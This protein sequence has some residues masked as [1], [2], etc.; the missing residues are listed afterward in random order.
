M[1]ASYTP[2]QLD[3]LRCGY[4]KMSFR[5]LTEAFNERFGTTRSSEQI[6]SCLFNH[7]ITSGRTGRFKKGHDVW[8]RGL[9]GSV[10]PNRTSFKPGHKPKNKR[11]LWAERVT[12][13]GYI[14]ISIPER[15]PYTGAPTRFKLK[16]KWLW[17]MEHGPVPKGHCLIFKDGDPLNC[18]IDNLLLVHRSVLLSLNL[19]KYR[20]AS[21]ELKPS[22]LAL[23]E[24]EAKAGVRSRPGRRRGKEVSNG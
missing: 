9:K 16:N 3:F 7:C 6:K 8:N 12:R 24:L 20:E 11:R 1:M 23:A 14:E 10:S 22:I 5:D 13:D 18:V 2:E 4:K 17:E 21:D 15:N 19:H